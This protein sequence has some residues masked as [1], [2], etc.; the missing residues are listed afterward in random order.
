MTTINTLAASTKPADVRDLLDNSLADLEVAKTF[1]EACDNFVDEIRIWSLPD[2][3][4]PSPAV[5]QQAF[6]AQTMLAELEIRMT[7][8]V[9]RIAPALDGYCAEQAASKVA[10]P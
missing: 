10:A 7:N 5:L 9:S 6:H 8:A 1:L 3:G 4:S 2:G